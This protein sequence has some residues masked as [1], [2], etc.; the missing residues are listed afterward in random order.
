MVSN[1]ISSSVLRLLL[2][3]VGE[4]TGAAELGRL[5]TPV[6]RFGGLNTCR[7]SFFRVEG[8]DSGR[9][10]PFDVASLEPS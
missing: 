9:L 2:R 8:A 5:L 7:G 3:L 1:R 10:D 6:D 4:S